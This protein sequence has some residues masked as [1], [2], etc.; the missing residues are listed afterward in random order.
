[1]KT[2]LPGG[3][4]AVMGPSGAGKTSLLEA[5]AGLRPGRAAGSWCRAAV[6]LDS[7]AAASR[8]RPS[9]GASATYRRTP[10]SSRT[11]ASL[12]NVRFGA[13]ADAAA[14]E[15]A[16]DTLELRPLARRAGRARSRAARGSGS[17]SR[18][19]SRPG[20]ACCCST[21]RWRRSTSTCASACCPGC[22]ACARP[23]RCPA[24]T[25]RTTPARR[26]PPPRCLLLLRSG[27]VE[28]EG[29]P[30]AAARLGGVRG[31]GPVRDREPAARDGSS[32]TTSRAASRGSAPRR[33]WTWP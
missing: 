29:D 6:L 8:W 26:W 30:R 25:S 12:E 4:T 31:R 2:A 32:R 11:S 16:I 22:C 3:L 9:G 23:G 17:R 10:G 5:I 33:A 13:R 14:V 15:A 20:R 27:R 28:A 18:A 19:R 21:S 7:G 1:M 24:S